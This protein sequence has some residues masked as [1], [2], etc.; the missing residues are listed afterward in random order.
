MSQLLVGRSLSQSDSDQHLFW[1]GS[2]CSIVSTKASIKICVI[3]KLK[4]FLSWS[5]NVI[6]DV[7]VGQFVRLLVDHSQKVVFAHCCYLILNSDQ[8]KKVSVR[9]F[10]FQS[11][12]QKNEILPHQFYWENTQPNTITMRYVWLNIPMDIQQKILFETNF[13]VLPN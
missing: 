12:Q 6:W 4:T 11:N 10:E 13:P 9:D 8:L 1:S 7:F 2:S 3:S 5:N